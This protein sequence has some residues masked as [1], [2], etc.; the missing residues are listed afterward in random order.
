M[1]FLNLTAR[2]GSRYLDGVYRVAEGPTRH[3]LVQFDN[4]T[5]GTYA[6]GSGVGVVSG[7]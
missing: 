3:L 5:H 4:A 2:A 7:A 1:V 6:P